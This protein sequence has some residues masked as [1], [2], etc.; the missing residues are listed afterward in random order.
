M[1]FRIALFGVAALLLGAHFYRAEQ[2][3]LAGSCLATPLLFFWRSRWSPVLLQLLAYGGAAIW[4]DAAIRLVRLRQEFGRPWM[5]AAIILGGV[6]LF[7]LMA[8][9]LLNSRAIVDRYRS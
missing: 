5:A 8:G 6:A 4:I 9:L 3:L 2:L 7:T 1:A